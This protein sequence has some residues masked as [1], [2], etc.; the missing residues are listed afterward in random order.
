VVL[1][2]VHVVVGSDERH[3]RPAGRRAVVDALA[4][5]TAR[6]GPAH[7]RRRQ[8]DELSHDPGHWPLPIPAPSAELPWRGTALARNCPG[9][10]APAP[11]R[12]TETEFRFRSDR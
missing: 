4:R 9:P 7:H 1:G 2:E 3:Q 11:W 10:A 5:V 6:A 12:G 8:P